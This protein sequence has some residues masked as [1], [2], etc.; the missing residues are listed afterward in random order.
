MFSLLKQWL[1]GG[2]DTDAPST[3]RE[4]A[5]TRAPASASAGSTPPAHPAKPAPATPAEAAAPNALELVAALGAR[6]PLIA[7]DGSI[8]GFEFQQA[9]ALHPGA[10]SGQHAHSAGAYA[11]YVFTAVARVAQ[12]GVLGLGRVP[13]SWLSQASRYALGR[14]AYLHLQFSAQA[15]QHDEEL[16]VFATHA[17]ALWAAGVRL[18]WDGAP[19]LAQAPDFVLLSQGAQALDAALAQ[20]R[21]RSA[22]LPLWVTDLASLDDLELALARGATC[23]CGALAR[24]SADFQQ[25]KSGPVAPEV[26]RI[27]ALLRK[28]ST[29]AANEAIVADLKADV[30]LAYRLLQL[31]GSARYAQLDVAPSVDAAVQLLG[32]NALYRWLSMLL[33]QAAGKRPAGQA[34]QDVAL[35]RARTLELFA[36]ALAQPQPDRLFTLGLASM[37]GRLLELSPMQVADALSLDE[38]ASSAL[39]NRDGPLW[40]FLALALELEQGLAPAV[41]D[42]PGQ[43]LV[44]QSLI[45]QLGG[46]E[47]VAQVGDA[48]WHWVAESRL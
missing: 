6:R 10:R 15:A 9:R 35:W 43:A 29:G 31:L 20:A 24:S 34:L 45:R 32:R 12:S 44:R 37:L 33:L 14:G 11:S 3:G 18:A 19:V 26:A 30:A 4:A 16:R 1:G 36:L 2:K 39:L 17:P 40:P 21:H 42:A 8:C 27:G 47:R 28:L 38:D 13:A 22:G 25:E 7:A 48:A 23:V 46:M 41:A 5:S